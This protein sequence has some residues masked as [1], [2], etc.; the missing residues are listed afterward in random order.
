MKKSRAH[1]K[2][3]HDGDGGGDGDEGE[4]GGASMKMSYHG[5]IRCYWPW[6]SR[7]SQYASLQGEGEV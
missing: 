7:M 3:D 2:D 1:E 4:G 6:W 5:S